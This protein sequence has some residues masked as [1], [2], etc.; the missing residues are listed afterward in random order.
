MKNLTLLI[1]FLLTSF[2]F[3][4]TLEEKNAI[5][6]FK[7]YTE[8][9][10]ISVI[11]SD[12]IKQEPNSK[13][14]A[15]FIN[16][17]FTDDQSVLNGMSSKK[18]ESFNIEKG[19][20][21]IN[22]KTYYGKVLIKMKPDYKQNL[23]TLKALTLKHL[24]LNNNPILFQINNT[25]LNVDYNT[26]LIDEDYILKMSLSEVKT[27]NNTKINIITLITK[28]KKN[29]EEANQIII[30]GNEIILPEN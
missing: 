15:I 17:A 12:S 4:Q 11:Y 9:S 21:K 22:H 13:P 5:N 29:I 24:K 26:Y 14:I 23:I 7:K 3:S 18:I 2:S 25:I 6:K 28:T 20:F 27:S 10:K 1:T 19:T 16:N 30:R 8:N